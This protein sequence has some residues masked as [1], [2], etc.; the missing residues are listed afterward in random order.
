MKLALHFDSMHAVLGDSYGLAARRLVLGA[1]PAERDS[2][3]NSRVFTGDLLF[4]TIPGLKHADA[5][6]SWFFPQSPVWSRPDGVEWNLPDHM[7]VY[8][9]CFESADQKTAERLHK[10]LAGSASYLGAMEVGDSRIHQQLWS[11]L[12]PRFRFV[13]RAAQVFWGG[14]AEA[15]DKDRVLF[16]QLQSLGFDPVTWETSWTP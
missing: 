11:K 9:V 4:G 7:S 5:V 13:G 15:D 1:L 8:A 12:I 3:V 2:H 16:E 14:Y 10:G 6:G